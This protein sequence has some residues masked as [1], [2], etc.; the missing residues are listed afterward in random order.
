MKPPRIER[1]FQSQ[2][3][4]LNTLNRLS[5]RQSASWRCPPAPT[6]TLSPSPRGGGAFVITLI[7]TW[8][9]QLTLINSGSSIA[10]ICVQHTH[11][12]YLALLRVKRTRYGWSNV[13][14]GQFKWWKPNGELDGRSY[15][16]RVFDCECNWLSVL[17]KWGDRDSTFPMVVSILRRR[18]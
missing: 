8:S 13:E 3:V 6:G 12:V 7:D 17:M 16:G 9:W 1:R 5:V 14:V 4:A 18:G 2:V 15:I 10:L 11:A